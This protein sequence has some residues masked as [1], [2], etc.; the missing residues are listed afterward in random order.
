MVYYSMLLLYVGPID[1]VAWYIFFFITMEMQDLANFI[2]SGSIN[3]S[4][5]FYPREEKKTG[6]LV[7]NP[8]PLAQQVT[9]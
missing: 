6:R 3:T 1:G 4:Y 2:A 5:N 8:G 9:T 7:S